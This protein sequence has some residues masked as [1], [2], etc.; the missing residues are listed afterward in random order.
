[1]K[2]KRLGEVLR[3]RG[4]VSA[5]NLTRAL[6]EQQGKLVHLGE[7]L[8]QGGS[9]AKKDLIAA[10]AEVASVPYFD[11]TKLQVPSDVLATIPARMAW[12]FNVLPVRLAD[13]SLTVVLDEPQNLQIIDELRF[14]TGKIIVPQL[15]F[16]G[17][18]R[19]AIERHY[20]PDKSLVAAASRTA[21]LAKDVK[22]M[23]F[24]S[25]TDQQRNIDAM[26]EMQAE[27]MQKSKTTPAVMLVA[28]MIKAA[29][30]RRASDI[31]IEPQSEETSIRLR[32]DGIL[33]EFERI[34]RALQNSVASRVK[35]L[36]DMDIAERRAP[37]DGRFLVK[38]GDRRL[39]R[40]SYFL[41]V[42]ISLLA[43][44]FVSH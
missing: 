29:A 23:E 24:I 14:K 41:A 43:E 4:N 20:G 1:M 13:K 28:S 32:V 3:E 8:L 33:R 34:P 5:E 26:R 30:Q 40:I 6:Q 2:K 18:I 21:G 25:S 17:E 16:Q 12:R 27:L 35:I 38:I 22:E 42:L 9:V 39:E 11:C 7:L 10:L 19:A 15:G 44:H 36:S 31:H 37:Q